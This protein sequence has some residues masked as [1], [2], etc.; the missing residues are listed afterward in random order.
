ML[1]VSRERRMKRSDILTQEGKKGYIMDD[2]DLGLVEKSKE[3]DTPKIGGGG[4]FNLTAN[5][6]G[7][8]DIE[9]LAMT[10]VF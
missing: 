4:S 7:C 8:S 1:I 2:D 6:Y 9:D 3:V 10:L 5:R